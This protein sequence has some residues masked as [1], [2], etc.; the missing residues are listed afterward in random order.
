VRRRVEPQHLRHAQH[1]PVRL[2]HE[3]SRLVRQQ[4]E[5]QHVF[6]EDA[7]ALRVRRRDESDDVRGVQR[8]A[9]SQT[10]ERLVK[11]ARADPAASVAPDP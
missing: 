10:V 5:T 11:A 6:I 2:G 4:R 8:D 3:R 1:D 9:D 7:R